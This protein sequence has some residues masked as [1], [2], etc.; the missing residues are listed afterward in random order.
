MCTG[1]SDVDSRP[2]PSLVT[3]TT[4]PVSATAKLQPVMPTS[5]AQER[6]AQLRAGERRQLRRGVVELVAG[7]AREQLAHLALRLVDDRRDDVARPVAVE[8]HDVLAEVGLDH[9]DAGRLE[10]RVELDLLAQHRLRLH[11]QLRAGV[12]ADADDDA[13]RLGGVGREVHPR[14][15][16]LAGI[17][18]PG[19]QLREVRHGVRADV[20]AEAR[21]AP[22]GRCA[23]T[24]ASR[25]ATV[26]STA[27]GIA[28]R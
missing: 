22:A 5:A 10:R 16:R 19:D 3:S 6:L 27:P 15:G 13:V 26:P 1:G 8:L 23:R 2:L 28:W 12:V 25:C 20:A 18:E 9:L 11:G 14:A 4:V 21:A 24:G 17:G 7:D